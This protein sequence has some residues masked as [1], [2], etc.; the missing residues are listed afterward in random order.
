MILLGK[1]VKGALS[2]GLNKD[3]SLIKT[4]SAR[5]CHIEATSTELIPS[6]TRLSDAEAITHGKHVLREIKA[7]ERVKK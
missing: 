7:L 2:N 1:C 4:R 6:P 3:F 5:K